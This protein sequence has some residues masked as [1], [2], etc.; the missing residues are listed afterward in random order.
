VAT[1]WQART[2]DGIRVAADAILEAAIPF[3]LLGVGPG[4][5]VAF[6]VQLTRGDAEVERH[7]R[8]APIELEVPDVRFPARN[9]TA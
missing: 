8:H 5:R 1:A 2:A 3:R 9:W 6:V 7:P 4:G